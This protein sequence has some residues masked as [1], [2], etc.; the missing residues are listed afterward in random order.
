[1]TTICAN[2]SCIAADRQ[3]THSGGMKFKIKTKLHHFNS[4]LIYPVGFTVGL[5]GNLESFVEV[6]AFFESPEEYKKPPAPK[7]I[8]GMVLTDDGELFMFFNPGKWMRVDQPFYAIGSGM[9]FAIAAL[10]S[11]KTP[12]EAIKIAS[13]YDPSTGNGVTVYDI[14]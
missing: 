9:H 3:A 8:E 7:G 10:E 1:M 5:C 2:T 6:M 11:G 4:P 12:K 14:N 13:K